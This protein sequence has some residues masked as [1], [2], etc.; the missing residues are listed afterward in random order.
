MARF[1]R[2]E[3]RELDHISK[4]L[5]AGVGDLLFF[6]VVTRGSPSG[7]DPIRVAHRIGGVEL[8]PLFHFVIAEVRKN[9]AASPKT[10]RS[11]ITPTTGRV[12]DFRFETLTRTRLFRRA[13]RGHTG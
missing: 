10:I 13:I 11:M 5:G 4:E 12:V 3:R 6:P 2:G 9:I 7:I 1:F 8:Q